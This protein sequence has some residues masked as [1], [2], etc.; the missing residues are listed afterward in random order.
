M[1]LTLNRLRAAFK[2]FDITERDYLQYEELFTLVN[3]L[4]GTMFEEETFR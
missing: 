1:V 3:K 4:G 2:T